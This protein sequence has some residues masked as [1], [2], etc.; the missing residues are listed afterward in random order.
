MNHMTR[1]EA[2][3]MFLAF[4]LGYF[5]STLMRGITATLAPT[6]TA[7]FELTAAQLGLLGGGYFLGIAAMQLPLGNWLDRAGP[8]AVSAGFLGVAAASCIAF[9]LA[10]GFMSLLVARTLGG[11]GVCACLMGALAAFRRS[12]ASNM[13]QRANAWM[14]MS[15]SIGLLAATLPVQWAVPVYGWR[16]VFVVLAMLFACAML[17]VWVSVP[18]A[19]RIATEL[20]MSLLARYRPIFGNPYFRRMVPVGFMNYGSLVA[21]QT[22]WAGPWLTGVAGYTSLQAATG[23]FWLNLTMLVVFWFW[24]VV[25]PRLANAGL[26][27]EQLLVYGLPAGFLALAG[28]AALGPDAGW[29]ALVVYCVASSC[30]ALTHAAVGM[31]FPV[32]ESGRAL[33]AFNLLLFLGTFGC[34]WAVGLAVDRM[35]ASGLGQAVAFQW[36]FG[37]VAG[38]CMLS[39]LWFMIKGRSMARHA[40]EAAARG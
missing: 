17:A 21:L 39:Y 6:L 28:V 30:L 13:Q 38:C 32:S 24:G 19:P 10:E 18:P 14:L 25:H 37:T 33:S 12:F 26:T 34:Q 15:G 22:L 7:H 1:G 9:A 5:L 2:I 23:L 11:I 36:A 8:R 40:V 29:P 16:S 20:G 35:T 3:A 27:E 31:A 4:A